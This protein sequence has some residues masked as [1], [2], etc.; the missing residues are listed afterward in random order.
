[1]ANAEVECIVRDTRELMLQIG[2]GERRV[3]EM[4]RRVN[5]VN[6]KM[7]CMREYQNIICTVNAFTVNGSRRAILLEELQRENRQILAYHEENR[8]LRE[9]I[10]ESMETLGIVMARHRNVMARMNRISKQ[11]SFKDVTK[12][13]P[14]DIDDTAYDKERFRKL[15]DD[16]SGFMKGCED[17]TSTDLQRLSQLLQENQVLR[18]MLSTA[19]ISTPNV[20]QTF[21]KAVV[22]W[23]AKQKER[24]T[25]GLPLDSDGDSGTDDDLNKTIFEASSAQKK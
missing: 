21:A 23:K 12:L 3:D 18:E 4:I 17:T 24:L 25:N 9:A 22:R 7:T 10:N 13:F 19:A 5:A 11:P 15:V 1:M 16:L 14:E 2:T 8:N 6:E 20:K